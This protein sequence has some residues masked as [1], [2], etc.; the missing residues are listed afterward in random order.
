MVWRHPSAAIDDPRPVA[1]SFSM[2]DIRRL[3]AHV[4]KLRDMPDGV[5]V[6]SGLSRV[7]KSRVCDPVLRGADRNGMGL[8][9]L[10]FYCTPSATADTVILDPTQADLAAGTPS[11]KV[12]AKAEA[13][14]NLF[15]GDDDGSDDD[16]DDDAWVEIP[17][18][19]P[20]CS[21]VHSW[22][23][24][25]MADDVAASFVSV[26]RPR[27]SSSLAP[28]FR[29]VSGDAIHADFFPFFWVLI[30]PPTL[31]VV[32]LGIAS[33]LA[34]SGMLRTGLLRGYDEGGF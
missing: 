18:V 32:L 29:D 17:L 23:K 13:S 2:A 33:L 12:L 26:S 22:G 16:D 4:I 9:R 34:R 7:W 1:D 27:P 19:T 30:M 10:P 21:A 20:F 15:V 8:W 11:S 28:S 25:I 5:L 3:S 6:L 14:Q 31:K 24:G